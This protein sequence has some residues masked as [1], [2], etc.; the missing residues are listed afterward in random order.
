MVDILPSLILL[1]LLVLV[2]HLINIV[3]TSWILQNVV[4][5]FMFT[6]KAVAV[7]VVIDISA[8]GAS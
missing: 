3:I 6:L 2:E 8:D 1:L 7:M 4:D 5:I